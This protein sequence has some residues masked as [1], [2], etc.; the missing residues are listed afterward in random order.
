M[1]AGNPSSSPSSNASP[2]TICAATLTNSNPLPPLPTL[3]TEIH[4]ISNLCRSSQH[5]STVTATFLATQQHAPYSQHCTT[6]KHK[7]HNHTP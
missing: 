4:K 1:Q 2:L 7:P 5:T 6:C 3:H